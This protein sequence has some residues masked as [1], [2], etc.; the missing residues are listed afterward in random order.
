MYGTDSS[1]CVKYCLLLLG[2]L[3]LVMPPAPTVTADALNKE[4]HMQATTDTSIAMPPIDAA[5][6]QN[7]QTASFGL[8]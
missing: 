3:A 1:R 7:Y 6:P 8:G 5:A 2:F 4:Q